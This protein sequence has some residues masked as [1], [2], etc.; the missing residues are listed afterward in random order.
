MTQVNEP[1]PVCDDNELPRREFLMVGAAIL[2]APAFATAKAS[3]APPAPTSVAETAVKGLYDS[4]TD[5]Q[6]KEVCFSWDYVDPQ[7]KV[8]LRSVVTPNWQIT[9]HKI[10]SDYYS[11]KQ[12]H[13]IHDV[14]K[15]LIN[16]DWHA[17]FEKEIKDD[18][19]G[20]FGKEHSIAIFG[21]PGTK[22]FEM[23]ITGRHMTLRADGNSTDEAA[24]GGPIFYGHQGQ[25]FN[26]KGTHPDN[27]FWP[28]A[29]AANSVYKMLDGKQ[30][31]Q[32]LLGGKRPAENFKAVEHRG[33]KTLDGLPVGEMSSDQK[34]ELEKV[35]AVLINPFR[36][37]D[38]DEVMEGLKKNGGLDKCSLTFYRDGD[39]DNDEVWDNWKLQGPQF[40]WWFRGEPHV[41][42]WV[43]VAGV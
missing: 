41:H 14:F 1:C 24:F 26:E 11:T 9:K 22:P 17:K 7:R 37:E 30:R 40:C 2:A 6:K 21:T 15:G 19:N 4:L 39:I 34:A 5:E 38:R 18:C 32:A 43:N 25:Q 13:L 23:V 35:L 28:Q 27:V 36:M 29:I 20:P 8:P 3:A 12:Q 10:R 42:V 31:E 33:T 16:P